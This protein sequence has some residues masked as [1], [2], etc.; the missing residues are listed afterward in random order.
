LIDDSYEICLGGETNDCDLK[1]STKGTGRLE[2]VA[3]PKDD[4]GN[5]GMRRLLSY[6][7]NVFRT[8]E[9]LNHHSQADFKTAEKK[10]LKYVLAGL[11]PNKGEREM[12]NET[13]LETYGVRQ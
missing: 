9:N 2:E 10:F 3:V 5:E 7:K 8:A 4:K 1:G 11:E 13:N 12:G 6:Y